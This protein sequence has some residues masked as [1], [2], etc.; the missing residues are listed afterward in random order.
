VYVGE[1][2]GKEEM[3][4]VHSAYGQRAKDC[5][6]S[7]GQPQNHLR[8]DEEKPYKENQQAELQSGEEKGSI[9]SF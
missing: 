2:E 4:R 8:S 5:R 1:R 9:N 3:A 6:A 7:E